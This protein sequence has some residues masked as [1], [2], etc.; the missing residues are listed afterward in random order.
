VQEVRSERL[1][2]AVND[3]HDHEHAT[4][5][6]SDDHINPLMLAKPAVPEPAQVTEPAGAGQSAG[7][8]PQAPAAVGSPDRRPRRSEFAADGVSE[9]AWRRI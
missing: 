5:V 9:Y 7:V 8:A 4:G 6:K 3:P 1:E 2:Q